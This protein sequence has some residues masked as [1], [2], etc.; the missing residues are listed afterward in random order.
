M[1][2]CDPQRNKKIKRNRLMEM[3]KYPKSEMLRVQLVNVLHGSNRSSTS[4]S[5][6]IASDLNKHDLSF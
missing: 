5:V 2:R 1:F 4:K 3:L 6:T